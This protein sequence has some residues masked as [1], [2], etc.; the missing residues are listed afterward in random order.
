MISSRGKPEWLTIRPPAGDF[1]K[2]REIVKSHDLNT[3]CEDAHC[4]NT[5]ECWSGGT[6]TFMVLG[7]YCTRGCRFC[8]VK[9]GYPK[10]PPDPKEPENLASAVSQMN[11]DYIVITSVDR[12]DLADQGAGHF[13]ECIRKVKEM[14]PEMIVEVLIPDFRGDD[15]CI[16]TVVDAGPEVIAHNIE[17]VE[18]L[19]QAVRDRR[20]NYKQSLLVLETVKKMNPKILTKSSIML[21]LGETEEE[22]VRTMK[23]LRAIGADIITFGQYLRSSDWHLEVKEYVKPEAFES[24]KKIAEKM[25]FIYCASGPFVRSSYRAGELLAKSIIASRKQ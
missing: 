25:G 22:V 8:A 6:A 13:A 5:S 20:A 15:A 18:R 2:I 12:D 4:P 21:G 1:S 10:M 11:L 23:D 3:V 17:T 19:Q 14:S 16:K 7:E 24:F 9:S